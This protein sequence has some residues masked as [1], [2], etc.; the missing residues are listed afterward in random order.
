MKLAIYVRRSRNT[1]CLFQY[2][3]KS[4]LWQYMFVAINVSQK[5]LLPQ[6]S[7]MI[8]VLPKTSDMFNVL[9][10]GNCRS[11]RECKAIIATI[12]P[13]HNLESGWDL[14]NQ[15]FPI[16]KCWIGSWNF[17]L[18]CV[19]CTCL[20]SFYWAAT[21]GLWKMENLKQKES[22]LGPWTCSCCRSENVVKMF[23]RYLVN[24][25]NNTSETVLCGCPDCVF[26]CNSGAATQKVDFSRINRKTFMRLIERPASDQSESLA[27]QTW[28][29]IPKLPAFNMDKHS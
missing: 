4:I 19:R 28:L 22:D 20:N 6:I 21:L 29:Q 2:H 1:S 12:L 8:N 16:Q 5:H 10:L 26:P 11:D 23:S 13:L 9:H 3:W 17:Y 27:R 25:C 15:Y 7:F 18:H 24:I 14:L